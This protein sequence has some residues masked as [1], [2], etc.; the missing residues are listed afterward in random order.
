[1]NSPAPLD[2]IPRV[3]TSDIERTLAIYKGLVEVSVL[4]NGITNY[5]ELLPA[6]MD[7]A[8]R[9]MNAEGSSLM[10]TEPESGELYLKVARSP[11]GELITAHQKIPRGHGIAGW[12]YDNNQSTLVPDA[13]EDPRFYREVDK[14]TGFHTRSIVCVPLQRDGK[15]FGV[16]QVLNPID[17]PS[18]DPTDLEAFEAYANLAAT[19]ILKVQLIEE[20]QRRAR[21]Q[22]ELEIANE[23]QQ[24]F[25]PQSLPERTDVRFASYYHPALDIGGDFFD[26]F[27]LGPDEIYFTVGDVS[28]KGIPAALLMAQSLS[29]LRLLVATG[30]DP[31]LAMARWNDILCDRTVQGMF[32]TSALG[33]IVPSKREIHYANAGHCPPFIARINGQA[34]MEPILGSPPI[35][36]IP[37]IPYLTRTITLEPNEWIVFYTDGLTE[38]HDAD[39]NELR[40]QGVEALLAKSFSQPSEVVEAL[41]V[42]EEAHRGEAVTHDDL[43]LLVFGFA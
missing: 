35:S 15:S 37:D 42:G 18:F 34:S 20:Q 3:A 5:D 17:K 23:I 38:S 25:L 24:G 7:V 40:E 19:A 28:G 43:T 12:V 36:I 29:A 2:S 14:K 41:R 26:V 27:E 39:D 16:L 8:K 11:K 1:M 30:M 31:G 13:Y 10:L 4:I 32:I 21:F 6:I 22:Q 33:R 9:V